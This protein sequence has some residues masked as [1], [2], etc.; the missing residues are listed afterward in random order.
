MEE[1]IDFLGGSKVFSTLEEIFGY[2]KVDIEKQDFDKRR[3]RPTMGDKVSFAW[4]LD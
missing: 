3:S 4:R 1:L 2:W